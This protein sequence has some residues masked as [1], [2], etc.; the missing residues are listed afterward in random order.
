[1]TSDPTGTS[2]FLAYV[3]RHNPA[4]IGA[5][6]DEAGWI[7]IDTLLAAAAEHGHRISR[8]A[9]IQLTNSPGKRRFEIRKNK[10]RA[11]QGHSI[12]IDLQL[13][14]CQ[15]PARLY[16]GTV[17]RYLPQIMADGLKPGQRNHVHLSPD[18]ATAATVGARRGRPVILVIDAAGMHNQG[19]QF[20]RASNGVWLTTHVPPQWIR[21]HT[22]E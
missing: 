17:E 8:D 15:P 14:P 7:S 9:L 3:L 1:M 16:H 5:S 2:R 21:P 22:P 4:A 13:S 11:A 6:L 10:I 20:Y 19:H 12:P 18:P